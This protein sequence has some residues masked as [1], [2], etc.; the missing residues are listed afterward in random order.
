[1][2]CISLKA[3]GKKRYLLFGS[4]SFWSLVIISMFS[5]MKCLKITN[6]HTETFFFFIWNSSKEHSVPCTSPLGLIFNIRTR[7]SPCLSNAWL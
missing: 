6:Q 5:E 4:L 1:M 3:E 2:G 7:W